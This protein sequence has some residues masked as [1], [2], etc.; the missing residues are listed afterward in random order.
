MPGSRPLPPAVQDPS[1][2]EVDSFLREAVAES[3]PQ[4]IDM[5]A[6]M[7]LDAGEL[8]AERFRIQRHAGRGG[9]G[10]VYLAEDL[11][12]GG[13]VAIKVVARQSGSARERFLRE[14]AVLA[15]LTHPS[16]V[17]YVTHG[18]APLGLP[19]L[20]MDWLDGEDLFERLGRSRLTVAERLLAKDRAERPADAA[21]L[22][23]AIDGLG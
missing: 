12:A 18:T 17:R 5:T 6:M 11:T 10:S 20:A 3:E 2:E 4:S 1:E 7:P 15:E 16:I 23:R 21:E 8:L 9:M 14:T 22:L 19:F 13:R